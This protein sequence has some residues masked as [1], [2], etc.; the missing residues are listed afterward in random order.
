MKHVVAY[1]T[2]PPA[3]L[4]YLRERC[5][6]ETIDDRAGAPAALGRALGQALSGAHGMIGN[7]VRITPDILDAAPLL[8]AASTISAG[9]DAFDVPELTRRGIALMHTPEE[10]TETTADLAF[11]LMLASARRIAELADWTRRGHWQEN[12]VEAQ[13]GV[14]LH[15]RTLGIV[16]MGRIGSAVARRAALGFEM[17]VIYHDRARNANAEARLGARWCE[18]PALLARADAVC[19]FV[20]LSPTTER[21]IGAAEL[22]LMKPTAIL[23]NCS[24]GQVIDEAALIAHLRDRRIFG[25]GL[26]VY[27]REPLDADS[28]LLRLPNV[29]TTPHIGSATQH[30]RDNMAMRAARNLVDALDGLRPAHCVNPDVFSAR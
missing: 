13:F 7:N 30:T 14:D 11:A 23:V 17:N 24:R 6:V 27:E 1:R 8:R 26:D 19:V 22:A 2:L 4:A 12:I 21:L 28:P 9:L 3:V 15:H 5:S 25:A 20:P 29:V 16:G 18:L 10:V